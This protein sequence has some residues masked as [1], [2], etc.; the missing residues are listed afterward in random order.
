M[1]ENR[2]KTL[3]LKIR[4]ILAGQ[5]DFGM[6]W[7]GQQCSLTTPDNKNSHGT[8]QYDMNSLLQHSNRADAVHGH[9][10]THHTSREPQPTWPAGTAV[11]LDSLQA[12]GTV[13]A[14]VRGTLQDVQLAVGPLEAGVTAVTTVAVGTKHSKA[15]ALPW[16]AKPWVRN[17]QKSSAVSAHTHLCSHLTRGKVNSDTQRCSQQ[18]PVLFMLCKP[19]LCVCS[20]LPLSTPGVLLLGRGFSLI[21]TDH[22]YC[23]SMYKSLNPISPTALL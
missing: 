23:H 4:V 15:S 22:C 3:C 18:L 5:L 10:P 12:G 19:P 8:I 9:V 2:K 20:S 17:G 21:A 7:K 6:T 1:A 14:G 13:V 11:A 16:A